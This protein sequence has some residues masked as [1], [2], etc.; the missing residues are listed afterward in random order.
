MIARLLRP[1]LRR[2]LVDTDHSATWVF[3]GQG[4]AMLAS[5]FVVQ[6]VLEP[7]RESAAL[8]AVEAELRRLRAG[9][10]D[11]AELAAARDMRLLESALEPDGL[12][13]RA[14]LVNLFWLHT[15]DP[16]Y[17]PHYRS[18]YAT[19]TREKL[20]A[21]AKKYLGA[22]LLTARLVPTAAKPKASPK[23]SSKTPPALVSSPPPEPKDGPGRYRPPAL[24]AATR[25]VPPTPEEA[26][27]PSGARLLLL[28]QRDLPRVRLRI[29]LRWAGTPPVWTLPF[30]VAQ[31]ASS[32]RLKD[33]RTLRQV[34]E[35]LGG[36]LSWTSSVDTSELDVNVLPGH[37]EAASRAATEALSSGLFDAKQ[38]EE[39][40][41]KEISNRLPPETNQALVWM[42]DAM[43]PK[44]H[45]YRRHRATRIERLKKLGVSDITRF[46]DAQTKGTAF[47]YCVTGDVARDEA[48]R[49]L[50]AASASLAPGK[51]TGSGSPALAKGV[52]LFQDDTR[53]DVDLALYL[54]VEAW[55]GPHFAANMGL[56]WF[57]GD[58]PGFSPSMSA[59]LAKL[60]VS[61][62]NRWEAHLFAT[63]DSNSFRFETRV[64]TGDAVATVKAVLAQI[65]A[66]SSGT[67]TASAM[68]RV[69][70]NLSRW[71]AEHYVKA[72]GP[73]DQLTAIAGLG[74]DA[75]ADAYLMRRLERL[76][77]GELQSAAQKQWHADEV[78]VIA[79]GAVRQLEKPFT[80]LG[81]GPVRLSVVPK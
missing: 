24:S 25:F 17:Y 43:F 56:Q 54:P 26:K 81:H 49:A 35:A 62:P 15:G 50:T 27:L 79:Y 20:A 41:K 19:A 22:P 65:A 12:D 70:E 37:L 48:V 5:R 73:V 28:S 9:Q 69:R 63:A 45:R 72:E 46:R 53:K 64:S 51:P 55:G 75:N 4:S 29:G 61:K 78:R 18:A 52:F 74:G 33:G 30:F 32:A 39:I 7:N 34:I 1:R 47:Y 76:G 67:A 2:R 14:R 40:K 77:L 16:W 21:V 8:S 6:A 10:I 23:P 60:G 3:A 57:F 80:Q 68:N 71:V 36:Q 42:H 59:Q 11:T 31:L 66:L 13:G 58:N 44:G 38:F